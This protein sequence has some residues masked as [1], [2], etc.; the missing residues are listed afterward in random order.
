MDSEAAVL[1]VRG[2]LPPA[3]ARAL[4]DR[5]APY[6]CAGV[7]IEVRGSVDLGVV[8]VLARLALLAGR[9]GVRL[10]V[11]AD[12]RLAPLLRLTGLDQ[13]GPITLLPR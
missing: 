9:R 1:E 10:Q 3:Q 12:E 2:P 6:L 8:D 5:L 13:L 11:R 7:V 4:A